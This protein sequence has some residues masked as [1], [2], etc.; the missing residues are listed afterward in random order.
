MATCAASTPDERCEAFYRSLMLCYQRHGDLAE[1]R[2]TYDRLHACWRRNRAASP[3]P[4][5]RPI[6]AKPAPVA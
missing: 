2:A 4:K 1:A 5:R 3:H 6:H